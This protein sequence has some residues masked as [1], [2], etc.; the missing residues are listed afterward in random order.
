MKTMSS[1]KKTVSTS[2]S[3]NALQN[4]K[5]QLR[6]RARRSI[7]GFKPYSETQNATGELAQFESEQAL[8]RA[9]REH[10]RNLMPA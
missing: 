6:M 5:L 1:V 3:V 9:M 8:V 2:S 7:A 4:Q 10:S